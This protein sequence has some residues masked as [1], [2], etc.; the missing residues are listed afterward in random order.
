MDWKAYGYETFFY[1]G[2][3]YLIRLQLQV[4]Y[5]CCEDA[6]HWVE[7]RNLNV[8][9]WRFINLKQYPELLALFVEPARQ[10]A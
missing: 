4:G 1:R 10:A 7:H 3:V 9:P 8:A 2:L 6:G 5:V